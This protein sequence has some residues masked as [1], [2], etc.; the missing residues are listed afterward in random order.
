MCEQPEQKRFKCFVKG[1][2]LVWLELREWVRVCGGKTTR[3]GIWA[4]ASSGRPERQAQAFAVDLEGFHGAMVVRDAAH[5]KD[6]VVGR[7]GMG[8]L[9]SL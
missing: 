5:D 3:R 1:K 8:T 6:S 2:T 7:S 9:R 4:G